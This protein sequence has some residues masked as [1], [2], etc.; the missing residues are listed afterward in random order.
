MNG[1]AVGENFPYTNFHDLN[2]DWVIKIAKDFLDQYTHIQ[3]TINNGLDSL[4]NKAEE[5]TALLDEWYRTHNAQLEQLIAD[6]LEDI[7]TELNNSITAFDTH[8]DQK[9]AS[10]IASIPSDYTELN[11]EIENLT[12]LMTTSF[13]SP[14]LLDDSYYTVTNKILNSAGTDV[15]DF[16][17]YNTTLYIPIP[18]LYTTFFGNAIPATAYNTFVLYDENHNVLYKARGN[19][20]VNITDYPTAKYFRASEDVPGHDFHVYM[21]TNDYD[22]ILAL[23]EVY[24]TNGQIPTSLLTHEN[25]LL[26]GDGTGL[27]NFSGYASS[28]FIPII[29]N[30]VYFY[31]NY[32]PAT[33]YCTFALYNDNFEPVYIPHTKQHISLADYPTAKYFRM[34]NNVSTYEWTNSIGEGTENIVFEI[35][36]NSFYTTMKDGI[37]NAYKF[38]N[39]IVKIHPGTYDLT[40]EFATEIKAAS[41]STGLVIGKGMEL[42]FDAGAYVK[43]IFNTSST[44]ISTYFQPFRGRNFT[45]H[46]LDIEAANCRYCV[47]D[48]QAST[49]EPYR[50]IYDNCLMKM[51]VVASS[52][53][54]GLYRQCIGGGLGEHGIIEIVGGKYSSFGDAEPNGEKT[55]I[56]YHNGTSENC[57]NRIFIKDIYLD[58]EDGRLRFGYYG[59]STKH[60]K[61]LVSGCSMGA[62]IIKRAENNTALVDNIEITEWNNEIR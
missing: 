27:A 7:A 51:T 58:G 56:S 46:N 21:Q 24:H 37:T 41:G 19:F 18:S 13:N 31:G 59:T 3:E 55:T 14:L 11:T 1:G 50:N 28:D 44:Y 33:A 8:A 5:L 32:F 49:S 25:T 62:S 35:G 23:M 48:E 6:A 20:N 47:H 60:T 26:K 17:G 39:S 22:Y 52:G 38:N 36:A 29:S 53:G 57:D 12:R 43:A 61:V 10:V 54:T 15:A 4:T 16:N 34:S 9:G 45:L 40:T 42:F 30:N 2:M